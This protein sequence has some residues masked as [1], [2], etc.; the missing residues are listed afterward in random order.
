M[1]VDSFLDGI[2]RELSH[3][4]SQL[5]DTGARRA[6]EDEIALLTD[7]HLAGMDGD[8]FERCI[9]MLRAGR[10]PVRL[11]A[12]SPQAIG[13]ELSARWRLRAHAELSP[14]RN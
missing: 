11:A 8:G 12:T 7:Y 5:G 4:L 1:S 6:V 9:A 13:D 14:A 3:R 2:V 10:S